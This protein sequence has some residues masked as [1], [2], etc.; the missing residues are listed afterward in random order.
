MERTPVLFTGHGSPMNAIEDNPF[1][2]EWERV[3]RALPRPKAILSVSAHWFTPGTLVSDVARNRTIHDMYGF[4][5]A[6]YRVRYDAPGAPEVAARVAALLGPAC[7]PNGDWGLDHGTWSVL[8]RLYPQ[9]DIPVLQLSVDQNLAPRD[10]FRLGQAL[11]PLRD[12]GV[13]VFASGNVVHNLGMVG[14]DMMGGFPWADAFDQYIRDAVTGHRFEAAVDYHAAGQAAR[15][16]VPTMDHFAPLLYA[17]GA[18][19]ENEPVTV[20]NDARTMGSMSM[21]GYL[22][23]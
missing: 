13:L 16:A 23:T 19:D 6:L 21:T 15:L 2:R 1:T 5:D 8:R 3:G 18:A 22:F 14:W 20:F 7:T 12:E 17:L 10:H 11:R 9:A 4:P